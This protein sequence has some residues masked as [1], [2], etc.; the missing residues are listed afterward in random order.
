[1]QA[2]AAV[3]VKEHCL[4]A[5]EVHELVKRMKSWQSSVGIVVP[6]LSLAIGRLKDIIDGL[7]AERLSK[8]SET[9]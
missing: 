2:E 8:R 1:M 7:V 4:T 5:S 3:K 9:A 6:T